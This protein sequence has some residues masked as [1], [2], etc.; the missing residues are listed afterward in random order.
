[1]VTRNCREFMNCERDSHQ[2]SQGAGLAAPMVKLNS[3]QGGRKSCRVVKGT[4]CGA[5]PRGAFDDKFERCEHCGFYKAVMA[6]EG[7]RFIL[8]SMLLERIRSGRQRAASGLAGRS[9]YARPAPW[10]VSR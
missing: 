4:K 10:T 2:A 3:V 9:A 5:K 7:T 1:M 6:E 8:S